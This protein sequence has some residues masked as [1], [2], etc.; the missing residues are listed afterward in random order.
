MH[1]KKTNC[2]ACIEFD[3]RAKERL[4][5]YKKNSPTHVSF[6]LTKVLEMSHSF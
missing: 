1:K 5:K 3:V 4:V 2:R 6:A